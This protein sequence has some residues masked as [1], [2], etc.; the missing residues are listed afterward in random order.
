MARQVK[1]LTSIHED[2][3][4]IPD[5]TKWV[6]EPALSHAAAVEVTDAAWIQPCC[7]CGCGVGWQLQLQFFFFNIYFILF[8]IAFYYSVTCIVVQ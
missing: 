7:G 2:A 1:N 4:Y 5:L 6:K 8:F 3:G